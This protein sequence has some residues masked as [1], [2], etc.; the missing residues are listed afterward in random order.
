[1]KSFKKCKII[2]EGLQRLK[3]KI[4]QG[5]CLGIVCQ[6]IVF[7]LI[8]RFTCTYEMTHLVPGIISYRIIRPSEL[9]GNE[10]YEASIH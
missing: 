2:R 7:N 10:Q 4:R 8:S 6:M 1:M 9:F 3:K 5:F